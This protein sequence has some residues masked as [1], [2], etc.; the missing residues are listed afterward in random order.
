MSVNF[1]LSNLVT[2]LFALRRLALYPTIPL[3]K[4]SSV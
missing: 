1:N 4:L 3:F 2:L